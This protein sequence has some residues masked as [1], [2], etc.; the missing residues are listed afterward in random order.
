MAVS[1]TQPETTEASRLR[2]RGIDALPSAALDILHKRELQQMEITNDP[3]FSAE[4]KRE[5]LQAIDD[6]VIQQLYDANERDVVA[7]I[8]PLADRRAELL[9]EIKGNTTRRSD[10]IETPDGQRERIGRATRDEILLNNDLLFVTATDDP[11]DLVDALDTAILAEHPARTRRLGPTIVARLKIVM[12]ANKPA[13]TRQ[14]ND[15]DP[16]R[17]AYLE[18]SSKYATWRKQNPSAIAQLRK[19]DEEL[20]HARGP[21]DLRYARAKEYFRLTQ[22]KRV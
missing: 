12:E 8:K 22:G 18:A 6:D 11:A 5:A 16:A 3:R 7:E 4:H 19:V 17:V 15:N 14:Y 10:S 21:V 20:A 13:G 9:A 1:G 2:A